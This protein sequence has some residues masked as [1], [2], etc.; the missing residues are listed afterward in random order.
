MF[1]KRWEIKSICSSTTMSF[2]MH[3]LFLLM[4]KLLKEMMLFITRPA[5]STLYRRNN[6][7]KELG[8]AGSIL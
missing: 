1:T 3:P 6:C 8:I 2:M 5:N 4:L 7:W